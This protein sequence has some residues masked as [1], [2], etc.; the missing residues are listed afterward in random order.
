M[1]RNW[2]LLIAILVPFYGG[3]VLSGWAGHPLAT[4]PVF[5][6][7]FLAFLLGTGR[8]LY[9]AG[10]FAAAGVI[11]LALAGVA[12]WLGSH[13]PALAAPP[14]PPIWLPPLLTAAATAFGVWRL[15]GW[16]KRATGMGALLDDAIDRIE[17]AERRR[18][19]DTG[20]DTPS[21]PA[22]PFIL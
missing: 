7:L 1:T 8:D 10:S 19:D 16:A 22:R 2:F 13:L 21:G 14:A 9:S 20:T 6:A 3:P 11:Q 12:Y 17:R 15:R 18:R 4:I 5:A